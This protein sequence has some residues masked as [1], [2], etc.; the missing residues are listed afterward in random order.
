ML[1]SAKKNI[2][3]SNIIMIK[4]DKKCGGGQPQESK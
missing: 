2:F 4:S 3:F 1:S